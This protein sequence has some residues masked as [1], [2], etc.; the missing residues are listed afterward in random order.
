[1]TASAQ[2]LLLPAGRFGAPRSLRG[3]AAAAVLLALLVLEPLPA[4]AFI[5]GSV[6]PPI[7]NVSLN[8]NSTVQL[9]Y[10]MTAAN[11]VVANGPIT[12]S[13]TQAEFRAGCART[14]LRTVSTAF[15]ST[16]NASG[17]AASFVF[18][19]TVRIPAD[20]IS[21]ARNA[22]S[23]ELGYTRSFTDTGTQV[24]SVTTFCATFPIT[25]SSAAGFAITRIAVSFD[26][27]APVRIVGTGETLHARAEIRFNGTG[28]LQATWE[29]AGPTSTA[30]EPFYRPLSSVRQYFAGG[31]RQTLSSPNLPAET[32][33]LYLLRLRITDPVPDFEQPVIRYFVS[34]GKPGERVPQQPVG[35]VAPPNRALLAPDTQFIWVPIRGARAYQLEL[36][37]KPR[38]PGDN[39]PDLGREPDAAP[40]ALPQGPPVAGLL[41]SGTQSRASLGAATRGHLA[42]GQNFLW[43]I[44][45]IGGDGSIVGDSAVREVRTP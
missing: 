27:G 7:Q 41:V 38:L 40:P 2:H 30:G 37:A 8:T 13:S 29:I 15:S 14:V 22:G 45:A 25:S 20:L 42:P 6:A 23:S 31:D 17:L 28:L 33:G 10:T 9:L 11:A 19:E 26:D 4:S 44:L 1:M 35:L 12:V 3:G 32:S 5:T 21:A 34:S 36:Y 24:P 18:S 39:L 16:K 43:R